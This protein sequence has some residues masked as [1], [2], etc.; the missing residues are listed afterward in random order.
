MIEFQNVTFGYEKTSEK[1]LHDIS[2]KIGKSE[3]VA[4][5][6]KNGAGKTT[7][8]KHINGLLKPNSGV[9]KINDENIF[10]EP[11]SKMAT[12]VGLAFQNPNH[13][14]FATTV[15][16]ELEFGPKNLGRRKEERE[17]IALT[18]SKKFQIEHLL[19]RSPLEL[20][21]GERKLISIA[22]VLTMNQKV[23]V[24][25]EPTYGQDYRQKK[26]LGLFLKELSDSGITIVIVSHDVDFILDFIPRTIVMNNGKIIADSSTKEI[27]TNKT[28]VDEAD[29]A[30]PVL[31]ELSNSLQ[32]LNNN[33]PLAMEENQVYVNISRYFFN[34]K[35]IEDE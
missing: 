34:S 33:F 16:E 25:D 3:F 2:L 23:L 4:I 15:K 18:I 9:V 30:V 10:K 22:S 19:E 32:N 6:G 14:L 5:V 31:V 11:I 8:I 20:S 26:R 7:L 12:I 17:E 13:Q 29:L 27:F 21:G 1:V 28:L 35:K 24:L